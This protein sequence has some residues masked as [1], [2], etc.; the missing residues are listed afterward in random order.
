VAL[1][2]QHKARGIQNCLNK[3][4]K[5]LNKFAYAINTIGDRQSFE[6]QACAVGC[7]TCDSLLAAGA[8]GDMKACFEFCKNKDWLADGIQKGVVEPDKACMA[9]C[10]IETCQV[11]C[12]GGTTDPESATNQQFFWPNGGCSIKTEDY[13][14]N[15]AYVPFDSPNSNQGGS[16]TA[17]QCC[18]N[19]LS[20]CQYVGDQN[21][22]NF[23]SLLGKTQE[24][25]AD[26]VPSGTQAAICA[27]FSD[28]ANCGDSTV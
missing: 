26:F 18:S 17:A 13:S 10:V 5:T 28:R 4:D 21:S 24:F 3:C 1:E 7:D 2:V 11:V 22:D 12:Q 19:A 15:S 14:Q 16:A 6:V 9:G 23:Q 20:L 25:C 27:W 8:G